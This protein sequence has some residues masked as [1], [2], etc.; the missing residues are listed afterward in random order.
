MSEIL[1]HKKRRKIEEVAL[2]WV[3]RSDEGLTDAEEEAFNKWLNASEFHREI[4]E[5]HQWNWNEM[6]RVAGLHTG[7][8]DNCNPDL[9]TEDYENQ[10]RRGQLSNWI[11]I[12]SVAAIFI[13]SVSI[14]SSLRFKDIE[15]VNNENNPIYVERIESK[16]LEDGSIIQLNRDTEIVVDYSPSLRK[17]ELIQGEANFEVEKDETRPFIVEVSG[18]EVRAVGTEFNVRFDS[19]SMDVIVTEGVVA[20]SAKEEANGSHNAFEKT[21]LKE[22][23]RASLDFRTDS[24]SAEISSVDESTVLHELNWQPM[25]IDFDN[26]PLAQ[27]INEF[28]HRNEIKMLIVDSSLNSARL[29]SMFWSDNI[30][31]FIRLLE[32]NFGVRAEWGDDHTIHLFNKMEK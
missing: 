23:Q 26:V 28:N 4:F 31:G 6:D 7:Y 9:L 14:L 3:I 13:F 20:V 10:K 27:I 12:G 17:V 19:N 32:S 2:D 5:Q 30:N 11:L 29:S 22:Y 1:T 24:L 8:G 16:K 21:Y 15:S 18:V 25:L